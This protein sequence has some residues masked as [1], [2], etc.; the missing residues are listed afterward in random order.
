MSS[1]RGLSISG[2]QIQKRYQSK[3]TSPSRPDKP[4]PSID[5]EFSKPV[6]PGSAA[7]PIFPRKGSLLGGVDVDGTKPAPSNV[8]DSAVAESADDVDFS[9]AYSWGMGELDNPMK[10]D[11]KAM[12]TKYPEIRCVPSTGR[13]VFVTRAA[14]V[15][16]TFKL[17][18]MQCGANKVRG[19]S[20]TQRFHERPGL[21][22]KRLKSENWRKKFKR[23]FQATCKRVDEL[24]RQGW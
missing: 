10:V 7:G 18:N 19:D 12:V 23:S 8:F 22:R 17:L 5:V 16:R 2:P 15:T 6:G 4:A 20:F 11:R 21:R 14:D 1:L 13:T 24:R 3:W 9:S